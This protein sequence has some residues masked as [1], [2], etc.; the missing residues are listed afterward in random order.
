[1]L[2]QLVTLVIVSGC[3]HANPSGAPQPACDDMTPQHGVDA[4]NTPAPYE[5]T[6]TAAGE[7]YHGRQRMSRWL[8]V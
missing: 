2:L 7:S 3:L 1:M 8:S 4:Q 5:L 6:V